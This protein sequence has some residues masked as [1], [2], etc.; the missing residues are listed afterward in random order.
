MIPQK[1]KKNEKK[2]ALKFNPAEV[3]DAKN[4]HL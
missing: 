2:G 1:M 3:T 4:H